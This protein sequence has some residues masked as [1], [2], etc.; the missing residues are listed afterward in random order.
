MELYLEWWVDH[1]WLPDA[2]P[3]ALSLP[4]STGQ[5]EKTR[6][7]SSWSEIKTG[8]SLANCPC[9]QNRLDLEKINL[10]PVKKYMDD[11]E[12]QTKI[13]SVSPHAFPLFNFSPSFLTPLRPP[14]PL[15]P[16]WG[17]PRAAAWAPQGLWGVCAWAPAAPS[18]AGLVPR[19]D[20]DGWHWRVS[21]SP[22]GGSGWL[23]G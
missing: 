18:P 22:G 15:H 11:G 12:K 23:W 3:A 5:R 9:G 10:L 14:C 17:P 6:W 19:D 20:P 13:C 4:S 7:K 21:V 1:V 8:K 16:S 2:H